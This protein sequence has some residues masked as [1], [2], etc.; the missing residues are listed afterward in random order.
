MLQ[1]AM[2]FTVLQLQLPSSS[3]DRESSRWMNPR[4]CNLCYSL[5]CW[6]AESVPVWFCS[7]YS[8][9]SVHR[10]TWFLPASLHCTQ[11][12]SEDTSER[13]KDTKK[14]TITHT[15]C[16]SHTPSGCKQSRALTEA[17]SRLVWKLPGGKVKFS[18]SR[19][20]P[21]GRRCCC[22]GGR[23]GP[24]RTAAH[25][26][27]SAQEEASWQTISKVSLVF[28][29]SVWFLWGQAWK[30]RTKE[31]FKST[32]LKCCAVSE[33]N[34][35]PSGFHSHRECDRALLLPDRQDQKSLRSAAGNSGYQ[36]SAGT[37]GCRRHRDSGFRG[38]LKRAAGAC[39]ERVRFVQNEPSESKDKRGWSLYF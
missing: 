30:I 29:W 16:H 15:H 22:L 31:T 33:L 1:Y 11:W 4:A 12:I 25:P 8:P 20:A 39:Y 34:T 7:S 19:T 13:K 32:W 27:W 35:W 5:N 28:L 23:G 10:G 9:V 37:G 14:P 36:R 26:G 3:P 6:S 17:N 38:H 2:N 24:G 18:C 21:A